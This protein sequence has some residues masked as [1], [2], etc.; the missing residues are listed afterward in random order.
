MRCLRLAFAAIGAAS[1][2][3]RSPLPPVPRSSGPLR[4]DAYVWQRSWGRDVADATRRAAPEFA[5][6]VALGAE[7]SWR[8]EGPH[9]AWSDADLSAATAEGAPGIALRIGPWPGP[10]DEAGAATRCV[11]ATAA[12]LL[13]AARARGVEPSELQIDFDC[14]TSRLGG[15]RHWIDALRREAAPT[16]VTFTALPAWLGST[17]FADLAFAADGYVLQVHSLEPPRSNDAL[18]PLCDA[19]RARRWVERAARIGAPF[20]VALPTYGYLA[21]FRP[22]GSL[23]GLDAEG[24]AR[25][26][27][28]GTRTVEIAADPAA[29]ASLVRDWSAD[30][31][32]AM[33]GLVWYRLPMPGDR[34][35]WSADALRLVRRGETPAASVVATLTHPQTALAEVRLSNAGPLDGA[36][37]ASIGVRWTGARLV[38]ADAFAGF[39][40]SDVADGRLVVRRA[41][42]SAVPAGSDR[43][44][45]WLR[46][47][48]AAEVTLDA[49]H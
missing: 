39:A 45:A 20:R 49:A 44:V 1:L 6:L 18:R 27:P 47:D 24:A 30:R 36:A 15:F 4:H 14:A 3:A 29:M 26:W 37:P 21:A 28:G 31:P 42:G 25:A 16:P 32:A 22:D 12:D 41:T 34:R 40:T 2:L 17:E 35:N 13:D 43:L 7:I 5:R 9:V 23:L 10:F 33:T 46:F 48:G 11:L 19:D 8:A 38:A